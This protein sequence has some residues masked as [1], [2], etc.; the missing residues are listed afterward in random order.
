MVCNTSEEGPAGATAST[1][2]GAQG[3]PVSLAPLLRRAWLGYQLRVDEKMA[4]AGF[5]DRVLP[6]GRVLRMCMDSGAS[7]SQI[8]RELGITRQG[9][10]K[11]VANLVNRGYVT[12]SISTASG[13]ENVVLV[14]TR[15]R[16]Y[17]TALRRSR[18]SVDEELRR[19]LGAASVAALERLAR[20]L[21]LDDQPPL[22]VYLRPAR[23]SGA[24]RR[25]ED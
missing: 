17:V 1:R 18:R 23:H 6:E 19:S 3:E 20:F 4:R 24:L 16:D 8:G 21:A 12:S 5:A 22:S 13:R 9:A 14:T 25:P 2:R 7:I 10:G 11:L 15:G